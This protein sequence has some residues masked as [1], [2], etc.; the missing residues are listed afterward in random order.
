MV[1]MGGH[2]DQTGLQGGGWLQLCCG[3]ACGN[4]AAVHCMRGGWQ[5][6][7]HLLHWQGLAVFPL[8]HFVG[9]GSV[10]CGM[11]C[12]D[13]CQQQDA[14]G[15]A[16]AGAAVLSNTQQCGASLSH[17]VQEQ[18]SPVWG[19]MLINRQLV[20]GFYRNVV[21]MFLFVPDSWLVQPGS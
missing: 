11:Q 18:Q 6:D 19:V 17:S 9:P 10:L 1:L 3:G 14:L 2:L 4:A 13:G 8:M 21:A 15:I 5:S 12:L 7:C 20:V 16:V